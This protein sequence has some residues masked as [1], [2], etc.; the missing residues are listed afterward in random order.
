MTS[1]EY[2]CAICEGVFAKGWSEEEAAAE[3][4]AEFPGVDLS[5]TVLVCDDCNQQFVEWRRALPPGV[6][7]QYLAEAR[8]PTP[9]ATHQQVRGES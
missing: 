4:A 2:R 7:A 1:D 5:G 9:S 3:F 6:D 8:A